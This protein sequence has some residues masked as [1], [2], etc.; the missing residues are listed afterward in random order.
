MMWI[1]RG[2]TDPLPRAAWDT[3]SAIHRESR[4]RSRT[5]PATSGRGGNTR[6]QRPA[7]RAHRT[8]YSESQVQSSP[9][10]HHFHSRT[11]IELIS[12]SELPGAGASLLFHL[13]GR[14]TNTKLVTEVWVAINTQN[15]ASDNE[16]VTQQPRGRQE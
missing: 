16:T 14:R 9:H 8:S 6:H 12:C 2:R 11:A 10:R 7:R 5:I 3:R 4:G 1:P 13:S 15:A